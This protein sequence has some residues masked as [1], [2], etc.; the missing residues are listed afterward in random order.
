VARSKRELLSAE[1]ETEGAGRRKNA[2]GKRQRRA[3]EH[4]EVWC[5]EVKQGLFSSSES[6]GIRESTGPGCAYQNE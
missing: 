4:N 3:Q 5:A 1:N 6:E 2:K